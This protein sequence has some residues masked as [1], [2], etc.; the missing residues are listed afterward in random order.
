M[1]NDAANGGVD[2]GWI[3]TIARFDVV[4]GAGVIAFFAGDSSN[5]R[6]R[7]HLFSNLLKPI[8]NKNVFGICLSCFAA[9]GNFSARMRIKGFELAGRAFKPKYYHRFRGFD[10]AV[11]V[12][13]CQRGCHRVEQ[14]DSGRTTDF[15]ERTTPNM[16][17]AVTAV[18]VRCIG[19]HGSMP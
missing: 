8:A 14:T 3:G 17:G 12:R 15:Q 7:I 1:A 13:A 18:I 2:Q 16:F 6:N 19:C 9:S 10:L 5:K 4:D 11:I